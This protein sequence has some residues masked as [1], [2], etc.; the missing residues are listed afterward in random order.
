MSSPPGP[1]DAG[2]DR[3]D[4]ASS[5]WLGVGLAASLGALLGVVATLALGGGSSARIET[6][7]VPATA[8]PEPALFSRTPI[9]AV[10]GRPLSVA[11]SELE[12][13][14]FLVQVAGASFPSLLLRGGWTVRAQSPAAGV[15]APT[16]KTIVLV[17][18]PT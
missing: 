8:P 18:S 13:A 12:S 10:V 5:R 7:T 11:R 3:D 9:P 4:P 15:V 17:V 1:G 2:A 16:G 6:I 14:G